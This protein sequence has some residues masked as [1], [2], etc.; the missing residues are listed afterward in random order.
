MILHILLPCGYILDKWNKNSTKY[1]TLCNE[2]E[3]SKY[4]IYYCKKIENIFN[5]IASTLTVN[6][7][8]IEIVCG[9]PNFQS[10]K[11]IKTLNGIITA[12][13]YS[14]FKENVFCKHQNINYEVN[15][16]LKQIIKSSYASK[17]LF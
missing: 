17:T 15:N 12:I 6:I 4:M 16:I 3:T 13:C 1:F 5:L 11:K 9:F 8:Y 10:S 2:I 14:I 7:V